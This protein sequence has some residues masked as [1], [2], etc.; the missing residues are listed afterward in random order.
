MRE[1]VTP[2]ITPS[3]LAYQLKEDYI[4]IEKSE[5]SSS[6]SVT[7][8]IGYNKTTNNDPLRLKKR[9]FLFL[10]DSAITFSFSLDF[11][12]VEFGTKA[13]FFASWTTTGIA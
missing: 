6:G 10:G 3:S 2:T 4:I 12:K 8:G 9:F 1:L 11:A 13:F 7:I 5:A